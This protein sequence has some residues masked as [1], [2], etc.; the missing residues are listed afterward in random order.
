MNERS[1]PGAS[2]KSFLSLLLWLWLAG[3]SVWPADNNI[4]FKH[5]T[6]DD[7]LSQNSIYAIIQDRTGFLWFGTE[8]GL[9]RY[10][11]NSFKILTPSR[12]NPASLSSNYINALLQDRNGNLWIGTDDGL[13]RIDA[14]TEKI[15]R[16]LAVP[17][18]PA[19]LSNK[20]VKA[21][22]EDRFGF[23]WLGTYGGGLCRFDPQTGRFHTYKH[24]ARDDHSLGNDVVLALHLD[25]EGAL[26]IGTA[27]GLSRLDAVNN[28]FTR[29]NHDPG[30]PF[31]LSHNTVNAVLQ[32][33]E[34]FVWVG[35]TGGLNRLDPQ[36]GKFSVF[37]HDAD[38][39]RS[40]SHNAVNVLYR[41]SQGTLWI[42]TDIGLNA[43]DR[44]NNL[45]RRYTSNPKDSRSLGGD[46]VRAIFEDK[47]GTLWVGVW[48]AGISKYERE[49]RKFYH[50]EHNAN[51]NNSLSNN[52]VLSF[53]E[54]SDDILWI[55]T[56]GGLNRWDRKSDRFLAFQND[57]HDPT[58]L[59]DNRVRAIHKDNQ[60]IFWIG[61]YGGGLNRFDPRTG[62]FVRYLNDPQNARSLSHNQIRSI[63]EDRDGSLWIG[64]DGGGVNRFNKT[65]GVCRRYLNDPGDPG[66]LSH[67]R[68][69]KVFVD[70][71]GR[72]WVCTRGGG[73][74]RYIP[75]TD[76][77]FHYPYDP[78][79]L[80]SLPDESIITIYEDSH[81]TLWLGSAGAGLIQ[82]DPQKAAFTAYADEQ[83]LPSRLIYAIEEDREGNL[84]VSHASGISRF[85]MQTR[86]FKN[87]TSQ[88]GL[89]GKDFNGNSSFK[90]PRTGEMFFGGINGFNGFFPDQIQ[91]NRIV[92]AVVIT[93]FQLFN[94]PIVPGQTVDGRIILRESIEVTK[95]IVL[96]YRDRVINFEFAALNYISAEKNQYAFMMEGF[97]AAW[98]FVGSRRSAYYTTLPPGRY[99]FRVKGSNNDGIWNEVGASLV[100]RITP[101]FWRTWWFFTLAALLVS[102]GAFS[103]YGWRVSDLKQSKRDLERQV[104]LRTQELKEVSLKDPLTGLRNRRYLEEVLR[105]DIQAF[106]RK[107]N[108]RLKKGADR[109]Q[110]N[111]EL[112]YGILM[113]DIDYFKTLNDRYGHKM[114]DRFLI[115]FSAIM[116]KNIRF[117]DEVIRFGG[118]EFLIILKN[119]AP[120][121]IDVLA[122]KIRNEINHI[123]MA[124]EN[125][126]FRRSCSIGYTQFP[127]Y[128]S[129]PQRVNFDR[130]IQLADLALYY[131]KRNGRN[132]SVKIMAHKTL[133]DERQMAEMTSSIEFGI[134]QG[135]FL[136]KTSP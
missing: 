31:S 60:G 123:E 30:N 74:D 11:G 83:G 68:V 37:K 76:S 73:L 119:T 46:N 49:S 19:G 36:S 7:G 90:S 54:E 102:G 61:T 48:G 77:F 69:F 44:L 13:N 99:T 51:S 52:M 35:T 89:Q 86:T 130:T 116:K 85:R 16:Y 115:Q 17:N 24:D 18:D 3:N 6:M 42:G 50:I 91:D 82:F 58:S 124:V 34:G 62:K 9:N 117:D 97:D 107:K 27:D 88:D 87:Y 120:D 79:D 104:T 26:W 94:K 10:D 59:S 67:N 122:G 95:E 75:E 29:Y 113:V 125:E 32:D 20:N 45:F 132:M 57:V 126:D 100:L 43:Y 2:T 78:T 15:T 112:V 92:P 127:F 101:P 72:L 5:I 118:E 64:T 98:N 40:L 47:S 56:F 108:F 38:D 28:S 22:V 81:G 63:C 53:Y 121:Y 71:S 136:I 96:S 84:W 93:G 55:G 131:A 133:P 129:E 1:F 106:L 103:L 8:D 39:P 14:R 12:T 66:S 134:E 135:F 41:D 110:E 21:I 25:R 70:R 111:M 4:N 23:L 128:D 114:G 80:R 105:D 65:S 33:Q 109:R